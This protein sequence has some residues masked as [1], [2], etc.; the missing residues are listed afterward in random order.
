MVNEIYMFLTF[1]TQFEMEKMNFSQS[2][3]NFIKR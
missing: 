3:N 1:M 2:L